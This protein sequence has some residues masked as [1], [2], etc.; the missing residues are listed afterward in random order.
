MKNRIYTTAS[1]VTALSVLERGLGFLYRI[2]LSRLIGA[3]GLGIYQVALSAFSLF[4]T[5]GTG[6]IP[7]TVS[8]MIAKNKAENNPQGE[9]GSVTAGFCL[10]LALTL[11][12][13][14]FFLLFGGKATFLFSDER[15]AEVFKILMIGLIFSS[16]YAVIRGSFW[17]NKQL[18]LPSVTELAEESVMVIA[19]VLLLQ[20][21]STPFSGAIKAAWAVVIS[22]F[23]SFTVSILCYLWKG[24][25]ISKPKNYLKPL[26]N[27]TLPITSVRASSS[28]VNSAIAVLMPVMLIRAGATETQALQLFGVFSG[29]V[30]PVLFIPSTIIGSLSLVL[31]PELSEDF[32]KKEYE[33]VKTNVKRGLQAALLIA[34]ALIPFFYVFGEDVGKIA[35][36]NQK[37]GVLIKNSAFLL[38]PMSLTLI[39]T[40]MLNSLGYEKQTFVY[41]FIGAAA[42]LLCILSFTRVFGIY[43]YVLG[44]FLSFSL[45]ALFNLLTLWKS[46]F[47]SKKRKGQVRVHA[48]LV[49][50]F[51]IFPLCLLGGIFNSVFKIFFSPLLCLFFSGLALAF[52]TF[53]LYAC[54]Q[55]LPLHSFVSSFKKR[56]VKERKRKF[57]YGKT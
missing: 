25:T 31:V 22:Y 5:I 23:F 45:N 21:V 18:L 15:C 19:G 46:C 40:G 20:N 4:L 55:V 43:S 14:L 37:A 11:P 53:L 29:M 28:F 35:F 49:P 56:H 7:I 6:G 16:L 44:L 57:S 3:E 26:F 51:L 1:A 47:K 13:C 34:C 30:L 48:C 52:C 32:Y 41:Y 12:A 24:G 17:G 9:S 8:R 38:L 27:A 54:L 2:V 36:A 33:K 39:S 10:S 42:L 50:I